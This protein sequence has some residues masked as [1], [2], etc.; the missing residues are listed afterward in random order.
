MADGRS[1]WPALEKFILKIPG[2][3]I[4][5]SEK[6]LPAGLQML[7]HKPLMSEQD[8]RTY[9]TLN[10]NIPAN[11]RVAYPRLEQ[12]QRSRAIDLALLEQFI[13]QIT[14]EK[15]SNLSLARYIERT[16]PDF[17]SKTFNNRQLVGFT[18]SLPEED[19]E[20]AFPFIKESLIEKGLITGKDI[21]T[22][23]ILKEIIQQH[24]DDRVWLEEGSTY[25]GKPSRRP[26]QLLLTYPE[27]LLLLMLEEMANDQTLTFQYRNQ[28]KPTLREKIAEI[29][30]GAQSKKNAGYVDKINQLVDFIDPDK[31]LIPLVEEKKGER[32]RVRKLDWSRL[33]LESEGDQQTPKHI[34]S[35]PD[36]KGIGLFGTLHHAVYFSNDIII[37][38]LTGKLSR[39]AN[40]KDFGLFI[41]MKPMLD[42]LKWCRTTQS[43]MFI[44]PYINPYPARVLRQRTLWT[45]GKFPFYRG[46]SENCESVPS[47]VFENNLA[48][49]GMCV[50]NRWSPKI[51][52]GRRLFFSEFMTGAY[53]MLGR[54]IQGGKTR[55]YR[56]HRKKTRRFNRSD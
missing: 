27:I 14:A 49:P 11:L 25:E 42:F 13:F 8:I 38:Q 41:S 51:W 46:L 37:E 22:L 7:R 50:P 1:N 19:L 56:Q 2:L 29:P 35:F 45:L 48:R 36:K 5:Y 21:F 3:D 24:E 52:P 31:I 10:T 43:R 32:Y 47:W 34:A 54:A 53:D 6:A 18:P 17:I 20:I 30:K 33:F 23:E 4:F 44:I 39:E 26:A 55:K 15:L 12:M 28:L 9:L 16:M 40:D